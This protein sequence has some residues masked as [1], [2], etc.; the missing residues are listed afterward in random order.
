[1]TRNIFLGII[2]LF[3]ALPVMVL[4][5]GQTTG[6]IV[7]DNALRGSEIQETMIIINNDREDVEVK[8][9][10]EGQTAQWTKFYLPSDLKNSIE[11][12][13]LKKDAQENIVVVFS[14]PSDTANGD[15]TGYVGAG[16]K[17]ENKN[18]NK[19]ESSV[20]VEQK[21]NRLVEIKVTDTEIISLL[22]SVIP[23]KYDIKKGE[24]LLVRFIFDNQSNIALKPQIQFKIK[25]SD[26]VV[27]NAI[28]LYPDGEDAVRSLAQHEI[29]A[30]EIPT[31][32]LKDGKYVA[33]ID[34]LHNNQAIFTKSF[35]F[36]VG[37]GSV[38]GAS[39]INLSNYWLSIPLAI[40]LAAVLLAISFLIK[41]ILH[42]RK[43]N[44]L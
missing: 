15:Y 38:L 28:F 21:I 19:N 39:A 34:F 24:N 12:F 8:L 26:K 29:P 3:L 17:I 11:S 35:K 14:V 23:E 30:L 27:Y 37:S 42:K 7:I 25:N 1:M 4:A 20:S 44:L 10:V 36:T 16:K 2:G 22:V 13:P 31:T 41:T 6:P 18:E 43:V 33:E 9:S 40:I 32:G 5:I